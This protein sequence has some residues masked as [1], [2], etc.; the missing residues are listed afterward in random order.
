[1]AHETCSQCGAAAKKSSFFC[2]NCGCK[3]KEAEKNNQS[4]EK[5]R[6]AE[7]KEH[8]AALENA[9]IEGIRKAIRFFNIDTGYYDDLSDTYSPLIQAVLDNDE[10]MFA[11]LLAEGAD[12]DQT[13]N[14][15]NTALMIAAKNGKTKIVTMLLD[16]HADTTLENDDEE[17]ALII[18]RNNG[19][20]Y[21]V[22]LLNKAR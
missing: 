22:G 18:A 1:M 17:T 16:H 3:L 10:E 6:I 9:R 19:K 7:K 20:R 12:V 15:N 8:Q 5:Q 11:A 21:I 2:T 14:D 4:R 13:D